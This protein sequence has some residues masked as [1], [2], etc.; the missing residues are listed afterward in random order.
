MLEWIGNNVIQSAG[1]FIQVAL[2][3]FQNIYGSKQKQRLQAVDIHLEYVKEG[4]KEAQKDSKEV[5]DNLLKEL[6]DTE[7]YVKKRKLEYSRAVF[8]RLDTLEKKVAVL[9]ERTK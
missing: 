6:E 3:I 5:L 1:F 9:E 8:N 2:F 4:Y 7:Q